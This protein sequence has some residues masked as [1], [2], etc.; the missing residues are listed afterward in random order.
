MRQR[1]SHFSFI[2]FTILDTN[3]LIEKILTKGE[4]TA[5]YLLNRVNGSTRGRL[6]HLA[7][8]GVW[9]TW[10]AIVQY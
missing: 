1:W 10:D 2:Q 6:F 8:L 9:V 5:M 7:V 4:T 3:A